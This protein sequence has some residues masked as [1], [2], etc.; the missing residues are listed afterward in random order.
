MLLYAFVRRDGT[1]KNFIA[2]QHEEQIPIV[3]FFLHR[4]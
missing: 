1:R 2:P 4:R 3:A